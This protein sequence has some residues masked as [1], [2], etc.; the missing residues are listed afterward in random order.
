MEPVGIDPIQSLVPDRVR[1]QEA[2]EKADGRLEKEKKLKQVCADFESIF[3]YHMLRKM[4]STI[5]KS[6]LVNEMKGKD[7]YEMMMDQ[8]V[9]EDLSNKGG[10][11]LQIMLFNQIKNGR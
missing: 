3:V 1:K 7:T 5:P 4:R 9:S 6:G 8:K 10:L 2:D 11:G